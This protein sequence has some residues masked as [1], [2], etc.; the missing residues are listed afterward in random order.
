MVY[1]LGREGSQK[2]FWKP[3]FI[4][5]IFL[6]ADD[7]HVNNMTFQNK[8]CITTK[9]LY[10]NVN[11]IKIIKDSISKY[12]II[13]YI[14][15]CILFVTPKKSQ[16]LCRHFS[17]LQNTEIAHFRFHYD[18]TFTG[19]QYMLSGTCYNRGIRSANLCVQHTQASACTH[20]HSSRA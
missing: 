14:L 17:L 18:V 15:L 5:K 12:Y 9:K 6:T 11:K 1:F 19:T 20:K 13:V 3:C 2:L 7:M 4:R 10:N 8:K 16:W